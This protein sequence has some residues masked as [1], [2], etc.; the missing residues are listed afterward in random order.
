MEGSN[1]FKSEHSPVPRRPRRCLPEGSVAR[2]PA[3]SFWRAM[4]FVSV[5]VWRLLRVVRP[6]PSQPPQ[7]F[8]RSEHDLSLPTSLAMEQFECALDL[9]RQGGSAGCTTDCGAHHRVKG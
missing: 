1:A 9:E 6:R 2:F 7:G 8:R 5:R 3:F 4:W